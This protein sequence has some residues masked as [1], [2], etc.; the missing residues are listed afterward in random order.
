MLIVFQP[1]QEIK[2]PEYHD[3]S[4]QDARELVVDDL[5]I[6]FQ[7]KELANYVFPEGLLVTCTWFYD[8]L[9]SNI[10]HIKKHLT[11]ISISASLYDS[12]KKPTSTSNSE[13]STGNLQMDV[14]EETN[15]PLL[16]GLLAIS[17]YYVAPD[18]IVFLVDIYG[19][20]SQGKE[21]KELRQIIFH[22]LQHAKRVLEKEKYK[23]P[24][25]IGIGIKDST[26]F[27]ICKKIM[28][29]L[30]FEQGEF[31]LFESLF[32]FE[33]EFEKLSSE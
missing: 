31:E 3:D 16:Q 4:S 22:G 9:I 5:A 25:S 17:A 18:M 19:T 30:G 11:Y 13:E 6:I 28:I 15:H 14:N 27:E 12:V 24:L 33:Q 8:L 20:P 10:R 21:E 7:N 32:F 2:L 29:T 1:V 23:Y 26:Y